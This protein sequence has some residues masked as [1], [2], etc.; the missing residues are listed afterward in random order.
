MNDD[1][2]NNNHKNTLV[3]W[4]LPNDKQVEPNQ[5]D[6]YEIL[7]SGDLLIK[8]LRWSD[9]GS[10]ICT[11]SNEQSSDSVSS[12]VYPSKRTWLVT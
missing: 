12:F 9:M 4:T 1:N 10:Y 7:G 5:S 8:D 11:V 3:T 6:K 2:S